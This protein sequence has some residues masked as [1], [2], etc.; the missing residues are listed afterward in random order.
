MGPTRCPRAGGAV[1][2]GGKANPASVLR[3]PARD[4][5]QLHPVFLAD[6]VDRSLDK[7]AHNR[8]DVAV[9][10]TNFVYFGRLPFTNGQP[11]SR[12]SRR[13]ISSWP[14]PS[15]DPIIQI[16]FGRC[17]PPFPPTALPPHAVPSATATARFAAACR[18]YICRFATI[19]SGVISSARANS[20]PS[21]GAAVA[22]FGMNIR[23]LSDFAC[24]GLS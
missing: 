4:C 24:N 10:R 13:A 17:L 3:R 11:A 6:H 14:T 18:Q 9:P 8:F 22:P 23:S 20:S 15:R 5:P 21:P 19:S 2:A 16:F 1:V 7:I 12:A